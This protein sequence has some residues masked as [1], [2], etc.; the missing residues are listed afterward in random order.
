MRTGRPFEILL[1]SG[2]LAAGVGSA[3]AFQAP[4]EKSRFDALVIP[5]RS[6]TSGVAGAPLATLE[7]RDAAVAAWNTWRATRGGSWDITIDRR[8]GAPLLVQGSGMAWYADGADTGAAGARP[9]DPALPLAGAP[10]V[11]GLER[12]LRAFMKEQEALLLARDEELVLDPV[13]SMAMG[14][15]GA[16]QIVFTRAVGGVPVEGDRYLFHFGHGRLIAF[17]A[18]RWT[19]VAVSTVPGIPREL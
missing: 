19:A 7:A 14:E 6:S 15:G 9:A 13:S 3:Q 10:T 5:D 11:A 16:W 12:S 18:T 1:V 4:H 8:S 2:V 17:G